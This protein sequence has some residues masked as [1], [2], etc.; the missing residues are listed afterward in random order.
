GGGVHFVTNITV[1]ELDSRTGKD[2]GR[3]LRKVAGRVSVPK[4]SVSVNFFIGNGRGEQNF[5]AVSSA[6]SSKNR[7]IVGA[8]L[9]ASDDV[10]TQKA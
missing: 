2:P 8:H 5:E 6:C 10:M 7:A 9:F 1:K 3:I 4:E